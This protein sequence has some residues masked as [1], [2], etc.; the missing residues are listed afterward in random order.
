MRQLGPSPQWPHSS[1]PGSTPRLTHCCR[2]IPPCA[3]GWPSPTRRLPTNDTPPGSRGPAG[4]CWRPPGRGRSGPLWASTGTKNPAYS[5]VLYV[6]QLIGPDVINTMPEKTLVAFSD[7]GQVRPTLD[8]KP[9]GAQR[10]LNDLPSAD[11]DLPRVTSELERE[12]V[13]SFCQSYRELLDCIEA[14]SVELRT[15]ALAIGASPT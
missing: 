3:A 1:S 9:G 6:E 13:E 7:H 4:R 14:R 11:I 5:D 2:L 10:V 12:G 15:S 8:A